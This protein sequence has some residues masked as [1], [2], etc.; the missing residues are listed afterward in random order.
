ME[1]H[2]QSFLEVISLVTSVD[3]LRVLAHRKYRHPHSRPHLID[4]I[5]E[6]RITLILLQYLQAFS[7]KLSL[8]NTIGRLDLPKMKR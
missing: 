5:F 7:T 3:L 1:G 6:A 4:R 2:G 8:K